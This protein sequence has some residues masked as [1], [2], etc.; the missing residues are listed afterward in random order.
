MKECK[1]HFCIF[2][3][4]YVYD[5]VCAMYIKNGLQI[6]ANCHLFELLCNMF[7]TVG[8]QISGDIL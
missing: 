4:V 1:Y 2:K 6:F 7:I 5:T 8:F 3:L